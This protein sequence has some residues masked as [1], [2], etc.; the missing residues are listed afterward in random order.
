[1]TTSRTAHTDAEARAPDAILLPRSCPF[2]DRRPADGGPSLCDTEPVNKLIGMFLA[3][4]LILGTACSSE[5]STSSEGSASSEESQT[6]QP[7]T[8]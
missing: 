3:A 2:P 6:V 8:A 1:M 4:A 7:D 5:G